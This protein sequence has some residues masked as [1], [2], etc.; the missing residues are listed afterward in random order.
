[1]SVDGLSRGL[2]TDKD[3]ELTENNQKRYLAGSRALDSL[4]TLI[5]STETFFH[6][7]NA[8]LWT[9]SLTTFLHRVTA[10]FSKRW[11]EEEQTTCKTPVVCSSSHTTDK[12]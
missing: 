10:E 6:P 8:G 3:N 7:S 9:L 4:E 12:V 11:K 5:T 2:Y 1:M